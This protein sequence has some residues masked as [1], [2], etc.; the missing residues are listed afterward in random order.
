MYR[1]KG[2]NSY[3]TGLLTNT[4]WAKSPPKAGALFVAALIAANDA[5]FG[6]FFMTFFMAGFF[7][8]ALG[9]GD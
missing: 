5:L 2:E 3:V 4:W 9:T 1:K 6:C 8:L 7:G